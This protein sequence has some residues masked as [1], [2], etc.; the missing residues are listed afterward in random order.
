MQ[1]S[2]FSRWAYAAHSVRKGLGSAVCVELLLR[3]AKAA[4]ELSHGHSTGAT[5][6]LDILETIWKNT[7]KKKGQNKVFRNL[8]SG[9]KNISKLRVLVA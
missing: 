8:W 4:H 2:S 5:A 1:V 9:L 6:A 7:V 3:F